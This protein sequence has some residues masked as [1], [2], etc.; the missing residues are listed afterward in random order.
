M[1]VFVLLS[2]SSFIYFT[3]NILDQGFCEATQ[4]AGLQ[5]DPD[6]RFGYAQFI[7]HFD[8][9]LD[10]PKLEGVAVQT[11]RHCLLR[12]VKNDQC[13]STNV[14]AF[15]LPTGNISRELLPTDKY[16]AS[17]KFKANH[18]FHHY[19]IMVSTSYIKCN[20]FPSCMIFWNEY[21]ACTVLWRF[22]VICNWQKFTD[23]D[24][25]GSKYLTSP[26]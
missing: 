13:F 8:H 25:R 3:Y 4:L 5:R 22:Y 23:S 24:S 1:N 17:E 18:T 6:K 11:G 26:H 16:N 14:G 15:Y 19:S 7:E 21:G 10:V 20:C 2:A 9:V 12:C